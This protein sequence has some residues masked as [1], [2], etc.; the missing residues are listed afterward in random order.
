M[1]SGSPIAAATASAMPASRRWVRTSASRSIIGTEFPRSPSKTTRPL[2]LSHTGTSPGQPKLVASLEDPALYLSRELSW[3]AFNDRVLEEALDP[4]T[5][6]ME[7]LKFVAIYGSNLDEF[8]M[9]R[10]AGIK[11]QIEAQV[12]KR[13]DDGRTPAEHLD[14]IARYLD[15]SLDRQM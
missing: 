3:L 7:R 11:Q 12:F 6:L 15:D 14:S 9:V 2:M 1:P 10:V 13:S 5:P 8:F 4:Q